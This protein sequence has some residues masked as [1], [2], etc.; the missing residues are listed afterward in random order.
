MC[1]PEKKSPWL[2]LILAVL[3]LAILISLLWLAEYR[4]TDA[5]DSCM[6]SAPGC[7]TAVATGSHSVDATDAPVTTSLR[8]I[9][10][11]FPVSGNQPRKQPENPA[12]VKPGL[13]VEGPV[14]LTS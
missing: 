8:T 6:S 12:V 2:S 10:N 11:E 5:N 4:N 9:R 14:F 13:I 1:D 3:S 7:P